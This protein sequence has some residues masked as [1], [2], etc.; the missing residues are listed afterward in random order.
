MTTN[1]LPSPVSTYGVSTNSF[2][3]DA[4]ISALVIV[5]NKTSS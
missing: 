5:I 4:E 3:L 2:D 1:A